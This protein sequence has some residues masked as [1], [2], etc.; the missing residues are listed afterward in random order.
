MPL[1]GAG[2]LNQGVFWWLIRRNRAG[3]AH[4]LN[5]EDAAERREEC[6]HAEHGNE[7]PNVEDAAERREERPHAEHGNEGPMSPGGATL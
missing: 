2:K 7:G 4:R 1:R 6:P 3:V 5:I